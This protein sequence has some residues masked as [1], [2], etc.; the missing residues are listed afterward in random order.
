MGSL[1][2][3]GVS[4]AARSLKSI[5]ELSRLRAK[6]LIDGMFEP[7]RIESCLYDVLK[8]IFHVLLLLTLV[9]RARNSH[10]DFHATLSAASVYFPIVGNAYPIARAFSIENPLKAGPT[11]AECRNRIV[12]KPFR[13]TIIN[14]IF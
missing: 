14:N 9:I 7:A 12:S 4:D 1:R 6:K 2:A 8:V 13:H 3:R 10:W 5:F 11:V